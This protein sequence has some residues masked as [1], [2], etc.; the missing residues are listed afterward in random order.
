MLS[1]H[2]FIFDP[3]ASPLLWL[4]IIG[5]VEISSPFLY[6]PTDESSF[7]SAYLA[8]LWYWEEKQS[9]KDRGSHLLWKIG[10]GLFPEDGLVMLVWGDYN[11][12][13]LRVGC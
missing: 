6:H 3:L 9:L 12:T 5:V 13:E 1:V 2:I 7:F 10:G 4:S 11:R 8:R